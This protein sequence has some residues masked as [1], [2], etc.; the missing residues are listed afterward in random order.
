MAYDILIY[1]HHLPQTIKFVDQHPQQV[2]ILDHIGKPCIRNQSFTAWRK[3]IKDL[4]KRSNVSCKLSGMVTEADFVSWTQE[5]LQPYFDVVLEAFGPNRLMFGSD[6]PVCLLGCSY[7]RWVQV[8]SQLI[9]ELTHEE[10]TQIFGQTAS[11][12][13]NL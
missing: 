12:V 11:T 2:F 8:V 5:Q 4:A 9:S 6:W 3:L 13:Y 7:G 1:E 10:Q